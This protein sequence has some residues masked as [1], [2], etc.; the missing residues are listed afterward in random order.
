MTDDYLNKVSAE[1]CKRDFYYFVQEFWST[2]IPEEPVY[3][4]HIKY[5]CKELQIM[6]E[7]L[8]KEEVSPYDLLINIPP[9]TTKTTI[10]VV[11]FPAWI[12][13]RMQTA[14]ILSTSYA[15]GEAQEKAGLSK[16][17]IKSGKYATY[18]P[19]VEIRQD[20][21]S[22]I[23][24]KLPQGGERKSIGL[25][26]GALGG[27]Y[28][29]I[30][31]DDPLNIKDAESETVRKTTNSTLSKIATT[32]KVDKKT[33][34]TITIMQRLHEDDP[35][36]MLLAKAKEGMKLKHI[37]LPAEDN[38]K[39]K[40][41]F[42]ASK[43]VDRLLDPVRLDKTVLAS[44]LIGLGSYD[45]AG[46]FGQE[47][48]PDEGGMI[49]KK[50]F[51]SITWDDFNLKTEKESIVWNFEVDGAFTADKSN[52]QS[53]VLAWCSFKNVMYIRKCIGVWE[54]TN[55]F[56]KTLVKFVQVEGYSSQSKIYIEYKASGIV[57][58]QTLRDQ[59]RLNV[60]KETPKGSKE[61]RVKPILPFLESVRCILIEGDWTE[62]F[63]NQ[64]GMFPRAKLKDKVDCLSAGI[65]RLTN[66]SN[67]VTEWGVI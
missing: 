44:Q 26:G 67:T 6:A 3:N 18:F 2:I 46:Q 23:K 37:N 59:T 1:L 4:W 51:G 60:V 25:S 30:L 36:G 34:I 48:A 14:R 45:Y 8:F 7:R 41:K 24:Y 58:Y 19:N 47:P 5:L 39:I 27:H 66:S 52:A 63:K 64:C 9:G 61:E 33:T 50:W 42:L 32:R 17:I 13:T 49:K 55:D 28:H 57:F 21:D 29:V 12:W 22:K 56:L 43:Y 40:P 65:N 15:A 38:G 35:S 53:A 16:D 10:A 62:G 54:E 11:M 20:I 31:N